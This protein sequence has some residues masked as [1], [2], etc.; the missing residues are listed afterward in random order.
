MQA[1]LNT[2]NP[3]TILDHSIAISNLTSFAQDLITDDVDYATS[4]IYNAVSAV[5]KDFNFNRTYIK[6]VCAMHQN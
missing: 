6:L 3:S 2:S 1:R 4:S 5:S